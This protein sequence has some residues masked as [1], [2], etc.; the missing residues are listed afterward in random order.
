MSE[1]SDEERYEATEWLA[2]MMD[3]PEAHR[4]D[5]EAWLSGNDARRTHYDR[6]LTGLHGS[7][8]G[9]EFTG[10]RARNAERAVP[11]TVFWAGVRW[12]PVLAGSAIA[13]IVAAFGYQFARD[14]SHIASADQLRTTIQTQIGEVRPTRLADGTVVTLDTGTE[15]VV[16]LASDTRKVE[17]RRGRARF[18]VADRGSPFKVVEGANSI[19]AASGTFDVSYRGS[20]T[21]QVIEGTAEVR[22]QPAA[23]F[24]YRDFPIRLTS[25][26]KL[27][28]TSGQSDP[29]SAIDARPS[30]QQWIGGVKSLNDVPISEVIAEANTYSDTR[31]VLAD[32]RLGDKVIFGDL[33]IRDIDAVAKAIADYLHVKVD[34]S[35]PGKL[36]LVAPN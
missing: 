23:Y 6:L 15:I 7:T 16:D 17:L 32:P 1:L 12:R 22:L 20:L 35:H 31:I 24:A 14:R 13:I 30:D 3:Q 10:M 34:R 29:P 26:Q 36:I 27:V 33:H 19:V 8:W 5:L 4:A 21:A 11:W 9:A 28:F 2:K 25:G 18:A